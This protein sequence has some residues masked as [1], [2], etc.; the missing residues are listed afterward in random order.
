MT[1]VS[2]IDIT[3]ELLI[4]R[5]GPG[6]SGVAMIHRK[7]DGRGVAMFEYHRKISG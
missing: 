5:G 6:M 1:G 7:L 4:A 2:K 3:R